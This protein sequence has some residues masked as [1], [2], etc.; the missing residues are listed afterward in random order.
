MLNLCLF[1]ILINYRC[2]IDIVS[3]K[4]LTNGTTIME[5]Y[6][7]NTNDD[8]AKL[9]LHLNNVEFEIINAQCNIEFKL[10]VF[11]SDND[12]SSQEITKIKLLN[13]DVNKLAFEER[14]NEIWLI[15]TLLLTFVL[16]IG[17]ICAGLI[18]SQEK[19]IKNNLNQLPPIV[20]IEE[21]FRNDQLMNSSSMA[22]ILPPPNYEKAT[23]E[24]P[25]GYDTALEFI[26]QQQHPSIFTMTTLNEI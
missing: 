16:F 5:R 10:C 12:N 3:A 19:V 18:R 6:D 22:T 2:L 25:P 20:N 15:L 24:I 14:L 4:Q 7:C 13:N 23:G 9:I 21:L 11:G 17:L 1:I 26:K 8:C